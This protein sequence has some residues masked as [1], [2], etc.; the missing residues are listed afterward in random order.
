MEEDRTEGPHKEEKS[1]G[2]LQ[3]IPNAVMTLVLVAVLIGVAVIASVYFGNN[4]SQSD[5]QS[6]AENN[7]EKL[8]DEGISSYR[9]PDSVFAWHYNG[10]GIV[11]ELID[12]IT[13]ESLKE[14]SIDTTLPIDSTSFGALPDSHQVKYNGASDLIIFQ[15]NNSSAYDGSKIDPS[16]DFCE[17]LYAVSFA[18][19]TPRQ[20]WSS[21]KDCTLITWLIH[22][23]KPEM[24]IV[25]GDVYRQ[26][27]LIDL[28]TNEVVKSV[29]YS[30]NISEL[31]LNYETG[32]L[33]FMNWLGTVNFEGD[34]QS[35]IEIGIIDLLSDEGRNNIFVR[36]SFKSFQFAY[37]A[38]NL[39]PDFRYFPY[40]S[41]DF[42]YIDIESGEKYPNGSDNF[43]YIDIE[44]GEKYPI[45]VFQG[46]SIENFL[47]L[48]SGDSSKLL[49]STESGLNIFDRLRNI[50]ETIPTTERLI[51]QQWAP[52]QRYI[53][54]VSESEGNDDIR[55]L[56]TESKQF[57]NFANRDGFEFITGASWAYTST[58]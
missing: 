57:I 55:V 26:V 37:Y 50:K 17:A 2:V 6:G 34:I 36:N 23:W 29:G 18:D 24:Y 44:S 35:F 16:L 27:Q 54:F 21:G 40:G 39:S 51:R 10:E 11:A 48:W 47:I 53:L 14:V 45:R 20:I 5:N 9:E 41:D 31:A 42:G 15:V 12:H 30:E 28:N 43:G 13:G 7:E 52:A 4:S 3:S 56:D 46:D 49:F 1:Q 32:E 38:I 33:A 19:N 58:E 25:E 22:P 8:A